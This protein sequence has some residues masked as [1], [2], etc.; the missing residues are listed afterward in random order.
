MS[1]EL[2]FHI[3]SGDESCSAHTC[4][5]L[6]DIEKTPMFCFLAI[7]PFFFGFRFWEWLSRI[8][9]NILPKQRLQNLSLLTFWIQNF[10][11]LGL[12]WPLQL[13]VTAYSVQCD[14]LQ[15]WRRQAL[16]GRWR[17]SGSSCWKCSAAK[18]AT[19][20]EIAKR[21]LWK[22]RSNTPEC[23][24]ER[25]HQVTERM[26]FRPCSPIVSKPAHQWCRRLMRKQ[27]YMTAN[28]SEVFQILSFVL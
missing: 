11:G 14:H 13:G 10:L 16:T 2:R 28:Q 25:F 7:H 17:D 19:P 26:K 1:T 22:C 15:E 21:V 3:L 27:F 4:S 18:M 6:V 5:L 9:C 24:R 12:V 20:G 23:K 8:I